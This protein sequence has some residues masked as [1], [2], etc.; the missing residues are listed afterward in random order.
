MATTT[1][2]DTVRHV[3]RVSQQLPDSL[4]FAYV[5]MIVSHDPWH[6]VHFLA[7]CCTLAINERINEWCI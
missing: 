4:A 5:A 3:N 2:V 7:V 1:Y 6:K